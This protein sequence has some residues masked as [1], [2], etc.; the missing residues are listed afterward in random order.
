VRQLLGR[1]AAM[2][3]LGESHVG[4]RRNGLAYNGNGRPGGSQPISLPYGKCWRPPVQ[5]GNQIVEAQAFTLG[6]KYILR[7]VTDD[8]VKGWNSLFKKVEIRELKLEES[9][10]VRRGGLGIR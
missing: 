8:E 3:D 9:A 2:E 4:G 6:N 7:L 1:H 5:S 10:D